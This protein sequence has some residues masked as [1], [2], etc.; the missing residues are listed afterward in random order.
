MKIAK[1]L[2]PIT[3]I[4]IL[5]WSFPVRHL[6][7][8]FRSLLSTY[9]HSFLTMFIIYQL[10]LNIFEP[11]CFSVMPFLDAPKITQKSFTFFSIWYI[12]WSYP[13]SIEFCV[14]LLLFKI[15]NSILSKLLSSLLISSYF[16]SFCKH[17]LL[18]LLN[19]SFQPLSFHSISFI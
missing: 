8:L 17:P 6:P 16:T 14:H 18:Q 10:I 4:T 12:N 1:T 5:P 2:N 13:I 19:H 11:F 15:K 9:D 7:A 3:L